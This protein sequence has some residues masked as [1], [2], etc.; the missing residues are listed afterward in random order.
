MLSGRLR[1]LGLPILLLT[2]TAGCTSAG[3]TAPPTR[4]DVA[5]ASYS[6]PAGAPG[7]CARLAASTRLTDLPSAIGVLTA[8]PGDIEANLDL[9]AAIEELRAVLEEVRSGAGQIKVETSIEE[10]VEALRRA[11]QGPVTDT[12]RTAIVHGLDD[13]GARVPPICRFPG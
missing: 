13:V 5:V 6:P 10:L 4:A 2:A 7:F 9:D 12:V 1:L 3:A 8:E 11:G